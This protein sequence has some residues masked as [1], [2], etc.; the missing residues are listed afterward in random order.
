MTALLRFAPNLS[1]AEV[2]EYSCLA[3]LRE[4]EV[5]INQS[6]QE[7]ALKAITKYLENTSEGHE[8]VVARGSQPV[9]GVDGR[10]ELADEFR[11]ILE[12]LAPPPKDDD[13]TDE[14]DDED[15]ASI[16]FYAQS[17]YAI[18][19]SGDLLGSII[20]HTDGIDGTTVTGLSIASKDGKPFVPVEHDSIT[21]NEDGSIVSQV[22][23]VLQIEGK[24]IFVSNELNIPGYVDFNT[25][26]IHFPGSVT[27]N[28]GVRDCFIV[29]AEGT[30]VVRGLVE[31]ACVRAGED[32]HLAGGMAAR[33]KG[34][35]YV[36]RDLHARYLGMV[37][38]TVLRNA[39]VEREVVDSELDV[40]GAVESDRC[41]W[42]GGKLAVTGKC[43]IGELGGESGVRTEL[44]AGRVL[45]AE[46]QRE[47]STHIRA[48]L[49]RRLEKF[50]TELT[51]LENNTN[52]LNA[53]QA[54][55]F[56]ALQFEVCNLQNLLKRL[57]EAERALVR[58]VE[59]VSIVDITVNRR[60]NPGTI[61]R[62]GAYDACF[63]DEL[64]GPVAISLSRSNRPVARNPH[65]GTP[66]ELRDFATVRQREGNL[67]DAASESKA[68]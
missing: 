38:G 7:L 58:S 33:E 14:S 22:D 25:G 20:P 10:F 34:T 64:K 56:T 67:E 50:Q 11:E 57:S 40:R 15:D 16:N 26:N 61:I 8:C 47:T 59:A 39:H 36:N 62:V 49:S 19:Q 17:K 12:G 52:K 18:V 2:N 31:A 3:Q 54:E 24:K 55:Q 28:K 37:V 4:A 68:A 5:M 21:I 27:V 63:N 51:H 53:A 48:E 32:L 66:I 45:K 44:I 6:V 42:I 13:T 9:H 23:G 65:T 1:Y 60:I 29:D 43:N 41:S 35:I 46:E 30:I